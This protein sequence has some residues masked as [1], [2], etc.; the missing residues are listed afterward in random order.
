MEVEGTNSILIVK[1]RQIMLIKCISPLWRVP[2]RLFWNIQS[3]FQSHLS[4]KKIWM[5]IYM[6]PPSL[7]GREGGRHRRNLSTLRALLFFIYYAM[8]CAHST[9][10]GVFALQYRTCLL[11]G[12]GFHS[13]RAKTVRSTAFVRSCAPSKQPPQF[14]PAIFL[15]CKPMRGF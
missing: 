3:L 11:S 4:S 2:D 15:A 9:L 8:H 1:T 10:V 12:H 7:R 13:A 6:F 5:H 14:S